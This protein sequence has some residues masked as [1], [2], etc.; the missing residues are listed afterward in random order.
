[1]PDAQDLI[2]G[3]EAAAAALAP[4][5]P[6]ENGLTAAGPA[7]R[8]AGLGPAL[9]GASARLVTA[10]VGGGTVLVLALAEE[11]ADVLEQGPRG[12]LDLAEVLRPAFATAVQAA[13]SRAAGLALDSL[14]VL[15]AGERPPAG[16][17]VVASLLDGDRPAVAVA[18]VA[19]AGALAEPE[20]AAAAPAA[21]TAPVATPAAFDA[22]AEGIGAG[23]FAAG[24]LRSL[25]VLHDVEMG[26]TAELGRT[27][28]TVRNL[29][30]LVPGSV[31]ELDRVAGSQV[32][33]LVN[34]TLI[35]RGE[36]VV[37]DDEFGVRISEVIGN[38]EGRR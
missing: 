7:A 17:V 21:Q 13:A 10:G 25:E 32:D 37:I 29:L 23:G 33:L 8:A 35:A 27:R 20:P 12:M 19:P 31:V 4:L 22:V 6:S 11:L 5:L 3:L 16:D 30:S 26:V 28:L 36:V 34:G 14:T 24:M 38:T 9:P 1:M 2:A 15:G 18:F